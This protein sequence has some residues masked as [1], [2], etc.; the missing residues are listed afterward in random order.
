M[1]RAPLIVFSG[2]LGW[3]AIAGPLAAQ[4]LSEVRLQRAG[5]IVRVHAVDIE[6]APVEGVVRELRADDVLII[7]TPDFKDLEIPR[8]RIER[9]EF[10]TGRRGHPWW[11]TVIGALAMGIPGAIYWNRECEGSCRY[12]ALEGFALGALYF[13]VVPGFIIGSLVRTRDWRLL[14]LVYLDSAVGPPT[15]RTLEPYFAPSASGRLTVGFRLSIG[16]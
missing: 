3:A 10:S 1:T 13:G 12:P 2:C 6:P 9:L 4:P 8:H 15:E 7:R 16:P 11:G 14:P 5:T